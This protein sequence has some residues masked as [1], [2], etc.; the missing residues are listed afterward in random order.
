MLN[1]VIVYEGRRRTDRVANHQMR[2]GTVSETRIGPPR[3]VVKT[4]KNLLTT[5]PSLV[6]GQSQNPLTEYISRKLF[7]S[8]LG[9]ARESSTH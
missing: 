5:Q 3:P 4:E 9:F 8:F 7:L 6:G 2:L 1:N